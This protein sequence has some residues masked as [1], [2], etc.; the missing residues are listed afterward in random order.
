MN[1]IEKTVLKIIFGSV[2]PIL[3]FLAGWW[4]SFRLVQESM[5]IVFA[6]SG[7]ALGILLDV[8]FLNKWFQNPYQTR[9]IILILIY[10]FYSVG[11]FGF[12][13][14]I[15]VFNLLTGLAAGIFAGRKA[16][17]DHESVTAFKSKIVKVSTFTTV[18]MG[19]ICVL[20]TA[21]ALQ[22]PTDTARNLEGMLRMR[23]FTIT[24]AMIIGI[25]LIGG[26][27]LAVLQYWLT[28]QAALAAYGIR[29]LVI[30]NLPRRNREVK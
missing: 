29:K 19:V 21:I 3:L 22:D 2:L 10:F 27:L 15:P 20:S 7:L 9:T 25:I 17:H 23:P 6:L 4:A 11:I 13:M 24:T 26:T 14:G 30:Q 1:T 8:L 16:H 28:R 18:I 12:F 5:V